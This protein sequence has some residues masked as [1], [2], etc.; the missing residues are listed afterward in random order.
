EFD[1]V[2][3][4]DLVPFLHHDYLLKDEVYSNL[5]KDVDVRE[6]TADF[7]KRLRFNSLPADHPDN[8]IP[9]L[10]QFIRLLEES[11]DPRVRNIVLHLEIKND[12]DIVPREEYAKRIVD[13]L[14]SHRI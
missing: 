1:V 11:R 9:T 14:R 7:I 12:D 13:V 6:M 5:E 8:F 2:P 3:S 10:A 4:V